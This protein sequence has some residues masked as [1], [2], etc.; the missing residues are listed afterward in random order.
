MI[1]F[2]LS[3]FLKLTVLVAVCATA[4]TSDTQEQRELYGLIAAYA[5][6]GVVAG[7]NRKTWF[8]FILGLLPGGIVF[9]FAHWTQ[10]I[11]SRDRVYYWILYSAIFSTVGFLIGFVSSTKDQSHAVGGSDS[12][13]P[14]VFFFF[15]RV[16][17]LSR[18]CLPDRSEE[19]RN[20]QTD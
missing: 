7:K 15:L 2:Q 4:F 5:A 19:L 1:Q 16:V 12:A 3:W 9:A 8:G 20:N 13:R 18:W 11:H 14:R 6:I 10:S 17:R